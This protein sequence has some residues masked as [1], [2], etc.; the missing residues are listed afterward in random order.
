MKVSDLMS[1]IHPYCFDKITISKKVGFAKFEDKNF[2]REDFI[3]I[4]QE[5]GDCEVSIISRDVN[6]KEPNLEIRIKE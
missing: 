5:F 3:I 1:V 4:W 2:C 6:N